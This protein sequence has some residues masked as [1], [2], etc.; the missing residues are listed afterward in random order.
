M[1]KNF[2]SKLKKPQNLIII[3]IIIATIGGV[4][5]LTKN[6]NTLYETVPIERSNLLQEVSVTG[7]V[8]PAASVNLAFEKSGKVKQVNV[9]IGDT[10]REGE[11]LA[12]LENDELLAELLET[13]G[14]VEAQKAKLDELKQGTRAEELQVKETELAKASKRL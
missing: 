9:E 14:N 7:R 3:I 11:I 5:Y 12:E 10:V 13:E 2:L 8:K 4:G 1:K 6:S